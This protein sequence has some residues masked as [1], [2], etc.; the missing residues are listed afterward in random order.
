[1]RSMTFQASAKFLPGSGFVFGSLHFI[2]NKF[3]DLSLQ[4]PEQHKVSEP[5]TNRPPSS[6][7]R[8]GLTLQ[9]RPEHGSDVLG[10][11]ESDTFGEN[12]GHLRVCCPNTVDPIYNHIALSESD[13]ESNREIFMVG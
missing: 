5:G 12:T 10:E 6:P 3:G 13:S 2:A 9:T 8:V 1:M 7:A 11:S 4:E